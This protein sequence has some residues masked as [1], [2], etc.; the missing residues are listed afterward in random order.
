M[1]NPKERIVAMPISRRYAL[2]GLAAAGLGAL[3]AACA[4]APAAPAPT[5][6]P[7]KATAPA[8]PTVAAAPNTPATPIAQTAAASKG[9]ATIRYWSWLNS[10]DE[11]NVRAKAQGE[12]L[13]LFTKANPSVNLLQEVIPWQTLH[14]QLLQAA[15]AKKAPDVSKQLDQYLVVLTGAGALTDLDPFVKGWSA[16]RRDDYVYSWDDTTFN[17]KKYAFR[18]AIQLKS[19]LYY[20]TD[21]YAEAGQPAPPKTLDEFTSIIGKV[22]KGPISGYM[23][24]LSKNTGGGWYP[25]WW[26]SFGEDVVDLKTGK[27]TFQGNAGQKIYQWLQDLV[28]KYKVSPVGEATMDSNAVLQLFVGGTLATTF[29]NSAKW[30][31]WKTAKALAGHLATASMPN[32]ANDPS[33]PAPVDTTGGWTLVMPVGAQQE[34]A[35]KLLDTLQSNPAELID[36]KVGNELPTRKSTLKDAYFDTDQAKL[37]KTWLTMLAQNH[38]PSTTLKITKIAVLNDVLAEAG[39]QIVT[40]KA[41][42]KTTLAAAAQKYDN[43][44]A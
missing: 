16:D 5:T 32:F 33:K 43:A 37:M 23:D 8:Q 11:K 30:S 7:S 38:H 25:S 15:A 29:T 26:W 18:D 4:Q 27:A 36:A 9:A 3:V 13:D 40:N 28:Y 39:Q 1:G 17:G 34:L 19:L 31:T 44:S 14:Q 35:W 10:K 20:R 21:L 42:V 24:G 41:D 6:V 2:R 22:T 12:M